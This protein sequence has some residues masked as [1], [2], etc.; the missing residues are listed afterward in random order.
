LHR[1][2]AEANGPSYYPAIS[3]D[4]RFVSFTSGA[5]N[6]VPGDTNN[7]DDIFV[8]E[9][10]SGNITRANV[11]SAGAQSL[12]NQHVISSALSGDGRLVTFNSSAW[13]LV[14]ND[15]NALP[16][17]FVRDRLT[18]Q[19]VR[20]SVSNGGAQANGLSADASF[21]SD[22]RYLVFVSTASNLVSGDTNNSRDAFI[23]DRQLG[24]LERVSV[25]SGGGQQ[26]GSS[27]SV[28]ISG[29]G[30]T[31]SHSSSATNLVGGDLSNFEEVFVRDQA[32]MVV[33]RGCAGNRVR[34]TFWV[35]WGNRVRFTF[36]VG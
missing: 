23:L 33:S 36:W 12:G 19:T 34:F 14:E 17:I 30:R 32:S 27:V 6:L 7:D 24:Q 18:S 4:G 25:T 13:N 10:S 1:G 21:S 28:S 31:I 26:N 15:T 16:D 5:T 29:D 11:S 22:G 35:G 20:A 3:E 9:L 2:G 8:L